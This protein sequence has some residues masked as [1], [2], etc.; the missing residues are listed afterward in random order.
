MSDSI[1]KYF[2]QQEE[3]QISTRRVKIRKEL[4]NIKKE[5]G[6]VGDPDLSNL[7]WFLNHREKIVKNRKII[8]LIG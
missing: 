5:T 4:A 2:D 8:D 1:S 7:E 3:L 6:L